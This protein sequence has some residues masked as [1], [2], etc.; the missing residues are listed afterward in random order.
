MAYCV[1]C[2]VKLEQ[3][4]TVCP[5]CKTEVH[6]AKEIIGEPGVPLF[7]EDPL[8]G[9]IAHPLLD[10]NRKGII[11]LVIA[12]MA[13]AIITLVI[14]GFALG[15]SFSPWFSIICV[16]LGGSYILVAIFVKPSYPYIA[17]WYVGIT[18]LLLLSID[19]FHDIGL[20]PYYAIAS[21]ALYWL[22]TVLPWWMSK[23]QRKWG[24]VIAAL[25]IA[26]FLIVLD[27]LGGNGLAWSLLIAL[28]TYGV[29]LFSLAFV[30]LRL[31]FGKP[32]I[33][34]LV[35]SVILSVCWGVVAGDFFHLRM[36]GSP[37]LLTWSSSVF[38]VALG[39]LL[40]LTLNV[41]LR[42]VRNYFNNRLV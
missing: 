37:R 35:L 7:P 21:V 23:R 38:I 41:T 18:I 3:G 33:T 4:S 40:F 12:F 32:T 42:R 29:V 24:F 28:P 13:I 5:L 11:E 27:A 26:V 17:S 39:L 22:V 1:R 8:Q 25:A 31:R 20:W 6:A 34:D 9:A 15:D 2:G 19:L 10:K 36:I 30:L 14:T 16:V